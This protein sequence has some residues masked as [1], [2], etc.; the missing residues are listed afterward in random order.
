MARLR[1][2]H[3]WAELV[4][5]VPQWTCPHRWPKFFGRRTSR[6]FLYRS[7]TARDGEAEHRLGRSQWSVS[8]LRVEGR[9]KA[10][11][12]QIWWFIK[13]SVHISHK[14]NSGISHQCQI[15]DWKVGQCPLHPHIHFIEQA[16]YQG[17]RGL[18]IPLIL[19]LL[20]PPSPERVGARA[21]AWGWG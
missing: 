16:N 2:W 15:F 5:L 11:W 12:R 6:G 13:S 9:L 8:S 1:T 21:C 17:R 20:S 7:P 14:R 4:S 10:G 19:F 3:W 18:Q